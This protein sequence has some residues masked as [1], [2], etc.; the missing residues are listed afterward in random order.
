M[1]EQEIIMYTMPSCMFC[2]KLKEKLDE[3]SITYI[4]K[5]FKDHEAEWTKV[6]LLTGIPVFPTLKI[7]GKFYCPNRDFKSD[8]DAYNLIKGIEIDP[9]V[10]VTLDVLYEG[11]KTTRA[12]FDNIAQQFGMLM[13]EVR[14]LQ[15]KIDQLQL[16]YQNNNNQALKEQVRQRNTMVINEQQKGNEIK[17]AVAQKLSDD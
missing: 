10:E 4:E 15:G 16:T 3:N 13:Q 12:Q 1:K 2:K 6:K 17:E 14:A 5:D 11:T 8:E 7:D 9:P